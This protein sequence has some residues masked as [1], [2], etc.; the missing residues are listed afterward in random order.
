[1]IFPTHIY[2]AK[3]AKDYYAQHLAPGDYY[4]GRDL[5][6]MPGVWQ[7]LGAQ[8][9]GLSGEVRPEDYFRL[10]DNHDPRTGGQLT[11]RSKDARRVLTDFTFDA[12][13]SVTLAFELGGPDGKGDKRI[14][15]AMRDSVRET[16]AEMEGDAMTRVRRKGGNTDRVTGNMV[17]SEHFHRTTR[18]VEGEPD[19]QLHCHGTVFNATFDGVENRWKAIQLGNIFRDKGYYQAAFHARLASKLKTL[20]YGIEKDSRSFR[21]AGIEKTTADKFS[22][23]TGVIEAEAERL[24]IADAKGRGELGRKTRERKAKAPRSMEELKSRWDSRLTAEERRALRALEGITGDAPIRPEKA[25]AYALEHAFQNASAVSDKRL[26]EVALTYAVGSVTPEAVADM[27]HHREVIAEVRDGQ[28]M[29]TTKAMLNDERAM[30][31]FALRGQRRFRPVID[32]LRVP[33]LRR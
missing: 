11:V 2:S 4:A 3:A 17:W 7:G 19:P 1:M 23:R 26:R 22:R 28:V 25:K 29:A 12:P 15:D 30:L 24:G 8:R 31:E 9:L 6:E 21:L 27:R 20:G 16:M 13:K 10:C 33:R 5:A 32:I 18:P 14:L